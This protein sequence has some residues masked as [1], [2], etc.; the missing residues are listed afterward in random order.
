MLNLFHKT[1]IKGRELYVGDSVKNTF[2]FDLC[3]DA[4]EGISVKLG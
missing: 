4:Y 2:N 1:N 3:L